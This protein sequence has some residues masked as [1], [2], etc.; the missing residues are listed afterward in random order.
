MFAQIYFNNIFFTISKE[1]LHED[2]FKSGLRTQ[3]KVKDMTL[4]KITYWNVSRSTIVGQ[5]NP[6]IRQRKQI[7]SLEKNIKTIHMP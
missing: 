1:V 6:N 7:G 2:L 5:K 4:A 3:S